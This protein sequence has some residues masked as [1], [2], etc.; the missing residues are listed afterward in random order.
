MPKIKLIKTDGLVEYSKSSAEKL[1]KAFAAIDIKA[2]DTPEDAGSF[3]VIMTS[4]KKDR[5]GEIIKLDAWS[6]EN[7]MK[8]PILI[9]G[10]NYYGLENVIGRVDKI[11]LENNTWIAEG[12]FASMAA[13]PKAQQ[14]RRLYDEKILQAVSVGFIV[15]GRDIADDSI[16]TKAELLELSFVPIQSNPDAVS[17]LK[18][19][20]ALATHKESPTQED[21][22]TDP[23]PTETDE[24]TKSL[25]QTLIKSVDGLATE[26]KSGFAGLAVKQTSDTEEKLLE[27]KEATQTAARGFSDALRNLKLSK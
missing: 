21:E 3:R 9:Y 2:L 22:P 27:L 23:A 15:K 8:N 17:L 1:V 26:I 16:I 13:N 20:E 4:D 18:S 14:V 6:F 12:K 5:D 11:Y 25:L 19:M 24:D 10:H 7:F